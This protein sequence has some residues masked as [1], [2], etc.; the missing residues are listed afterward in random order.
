VRDQPTDLSSVRRQVFVSTELREMI[1]EN[2]DELS[3]LLR[4]AF[5]LR[6]VQGYSTGEAAKKL[7]VT[8]NTLKTLVARSAPTCRS[9]GT[10]VAS[11]QGRRYR[12]SGI[13]RRDDGRRGLQ[14]LLTIHPLLRAG[15]CWTG[16]CQGA[17]RDTYSRAAHEL[18]FFGTR[19][20]LR[21]QRTSDSGACD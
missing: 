10:S 13:R 2:L 8:E 3:P 15:A 19:I 5:V 6:D 1:S 21:S 14:L 9:A 11:H 17:L 16:P 18:E 7:G 4:T 12:R 20:D